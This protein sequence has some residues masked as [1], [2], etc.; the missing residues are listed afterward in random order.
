MPPS[1]RCA[2]AVVDGSAI[3]ADV[4]VPNRPASGA[5]TAALPVAI[6]IHGGAFTLGHSGMVS[7][8]QIDDCLA[9]G[10]LVV[11]IDHRLCPQVDMLAGPI[12]DAR[13]ALAWVHST[14]PDSSLDAELRAHGH[15]RVCVDREAV[16]A[17]GTSSGGTLALALGWG[18]G[19]G[20]PEE[21]PGV[22]AVLALYGAT[23]F[24]DPFWS[25]PLPFIPVPEGATEEFINRVYDEVPVPTQGGVS[26][27]GQQ[28]GG[29]AAD[30]AQRERDRIRHAFAFTHIARGTLL[31]VA[32]PSKRWEQIDAT[33]NISPSFPPTCIVHGTEDKMVPGYLSRKLFAELQ[34]HGVKSEFIDVPG[35]GHTF[36]GKMVKG[37]RTWELQ[38]RGFD[39]LE[40]VIGTRR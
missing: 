14:S 10:W 31:D 30:E 4:Y 35:E 18:G 12:A 40:E 2:Y 5:H 36:V 28:G 32:F 29:D 26:L 37:S 38:R 33:L 39:F 11:S 21:G 20:G 23:A 7:G 24:G 1:F 22:K 27:E 6:G 8:D 34:R 25:T 15:E 19:G 17:F 13:A 16:V 9:R 3:H